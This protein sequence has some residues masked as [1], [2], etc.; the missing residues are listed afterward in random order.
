MPQ[1]LINVPAGAEVWRV[2]QD[3]WLVY[4]IP[5]TNPPVPMGW[6]VPAAEIAALGI[7]GQ[8]RVLDPADF[9][10]TG[11]LDMG[12]STEIPRTAEGVHPFDVMIREYQTELNV[13]PYLAD[14]EI[15]ALWAGAAMEGRGITNAELQG[16]NWWRTHN[17]QER[18]W[19]E[20]NASDPATAN[21]QIEANRLN[22][23]SM[24]SQMGIDNASAELIDF[25]ADRWT[26]GAW[27]QAE[28]T[29][30]MSYLAD[31]YARGNLSPDLARFVSGLDTT[32][33]REE[34]VRSLV[35][36]WLG[37]AYAA[38]WNG[39]TLA[40]WAGEFR[41]NPD[42]ETELTEILRGQRLALFP[43]HTNPNLTYEDIAGP[44]R[45]VWNQQWGEMP[46][47]HN[48]LFSQIVRMNDI[49]E[50]TRLL[51]V[52]GLKQ[53]N[54]TVSQNL[55]GDVAGVFGG[56]IYKTPEFR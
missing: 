32:R 2:G 43:E 1:N 53:G 48:P 28:A 16:T 6:K 5:N 33:G 42:A 46:D 40:R 25:V 15:L 13:R 21:Q 34:D 19:I 36:R 54:A 14:P 18:Q 44:W 26:T 20:L 41:N 47:E 12:V 17:A 4:Y 9:S 22:V 29:S 30:Q 7:S 50:A 23:M 45:Q 11:I 3:T 10:R 49:T 52:E 39:E 35:S 51:R 38:G 8:D 55:L 27:S 56:Q 31:P 24:M 37:P